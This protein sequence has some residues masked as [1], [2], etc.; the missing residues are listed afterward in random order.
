M[1]DKGVEVYFE[2]E[3]IYTM[4]SKGE[5]LITIM[6]PLAQEESRSI[7]ENVALKR[8]KCEEGRYT[9]HTSSFAMRKGR[10]DSPWIVEDQAETVRL[11]YKLFL[12]GL[13]PSALRKGHGTANSVSGK[14]VWYSAR[15]RASSQTKST[16]VMH[17]CKTFCVNF[18]TK[19]TV[20]EE[21]CR[22]TMWNRATRDRFAEVSTH[23][24]GA[25]TSP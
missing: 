15:L 14:P 23:T 17:Y 2:K 19:E 24:A 1:K 21:N 10:M 18:L 3:N 11:I 4:D 13:M 6:S 12:D 20:T 9:C 16:K 5:L 25:Q 22:N 8:A 7:S